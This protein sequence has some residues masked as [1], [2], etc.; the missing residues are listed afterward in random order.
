MPRVLKSS[1]LFAL[2]V[3]LAVGSN[4]S[5][6]DDLS[7]RLGQPDNG[8]PLPPSMVTSEWSMAQWQNGLLVFHSAAVPCTS[9]DL[10]NLV[11]ADKSGAI[12]VKQAVWL[13]G[14][15]SMQLLGTAVSTEHIIAVTGY[16]SST[17]E[18]E[19]PFV[20]E[21]RPDGSVLRVIKT[22]GFLAFN[23]AYDAKGDLWMAGSQAMEQ[24]H[25]PAHKILR[26][27]RAGTLQAEMLP[28]AEFLPRYEARTSDKSHPAMHGG[29][30]RAFLVPLAD[31][32]G[33]WS[34]G[35]HE[36]I[37]VGSGG[38]VQGRWQVPFPSTTASA[39][40]V[41]EQ[42]VSEGGPTQ[43]L[44]LAATSSGEVVASIYAPLTKYRLYRLDKRS[45]NWQEIAAANGDA[46][47]VGAIAGADGNRVVYR[48]RSALGEW[49]VSALVHE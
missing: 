5:F 48:H 46:S 15:S 36:W 42:G 47:P 32:V 3:V 6:A 26:R 1:F 25:W 21:M 18:A 29:E 43:L 17:S 23:L 11:A 10:P 20:E 44:G 45:S 22:G 28:Y 39:H 4:A 41:T 12:L 8:I 37:E 9:P 30:G 31:G 7:Y 34:P 27:Y 38:T 49:A 13:A 2:G 24:N 16:A 19:I 14:A 40:P 33:L 35:T